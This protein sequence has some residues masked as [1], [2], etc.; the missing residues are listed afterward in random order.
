M[1]AENKQ[2]TVAVAGHWLIGCLPLADVRMQDALSD[3]RS[4]F[5]K[6]LDVEVHPLANSERITSLREVLV[7]KCKIEFV[8]VPSR[9]HEAPEKRWSHR[10]A[11]EVF[12]AFAIVSDYCISGE[13]H[14]PTKPNDF[15]FAFTHQLGRFFALTGASLHASRHGAKQLS[16]PLMVVNKDFVSCFQVGQLVG[17]EGAG[18][19]RQTLSR[20]DDSLPY[21]PTGVAR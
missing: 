3:S 21:D 20:R 19:G 2:I 14:L 13:L 16:V 12:Q 18:P 11:K 6:L 4:D 7:P 5:V 9:P 10:T 15:Q 1:S 8:A 17:V